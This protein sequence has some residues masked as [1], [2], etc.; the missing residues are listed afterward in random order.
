LDE[1]RIFLSQWFSPHEIS[2][3]ETSFNHNINRLTSRAVQVYGDLSSQMETHPRRD[4]AT[5]DLLMP[6]NLDK[7][8]STMY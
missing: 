8:S 1:T 2:T 3:E 5:A 4:L 6:A 7:R